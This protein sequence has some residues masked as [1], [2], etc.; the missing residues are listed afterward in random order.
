[1]QE[2]RHEIFSPLAAIRSALILVAGRCEDPAVQKYLD[3][4][5]GQLQEIAQVLRR[6]RP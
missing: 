6:I 5:D 1:M 3:L 4:A 2:L